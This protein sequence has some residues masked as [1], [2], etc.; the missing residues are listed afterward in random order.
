MLWWQSDGKV[1]AHRVAIL[2]HTIR[3]LIYV[4]VEQY[5][6][7][8]ITHH[9]VVQAHT[10]PIVIF[11]AMDKLPQLLMVRLVVV[12]NNFTICR[13]TRVVLVQW[14]HEVTVHCAVELPHITSIVTYAVVLR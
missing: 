1:T 12:S 2:S 5:I 7:G 4:V 9:A 10:T 6:Y 8:E 3:T 11:V 14:H 13:L